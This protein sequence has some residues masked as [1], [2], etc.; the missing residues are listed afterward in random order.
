MRV[1]VDRHRMQLVIAG[2]G[3]P[4]LVLEGSGGSSSRIW[5]TL[6]P[7]LATL[8]RAV[9]YDGAGLGTSEPSTRKRSARAIAEDLHSALHVAKLPSPDVIVAHSR[10]ELHHV[11]PRAIDA[12]QPSRARRDGHSRPPELIG[13]GTGRAAE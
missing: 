5:R 11:Q 8:T 2:S 13:R 1:S 9:A 3:T 4:T 12:G 6:Q 7:A 10:K